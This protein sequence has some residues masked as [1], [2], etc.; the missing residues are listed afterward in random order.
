MNDA[1]GDPRLRASVSS[2][3]AKL[4]ASRESAFA[5]LPAGDSVRDRARAIRA[6]TLAHLDR[7]LAEFAR[8]ARTAGA[9]VHWAED[10]AA[11]TR[12]VVDIA[13][14]HGARLAVKSKSMVTE[15]VAL[16]AALE[17]AGLKV[18]ETDL[19]EFV[20]QVAGEHP[21]HI[22]TPIIHKTRGDV[23]RLFVER[24]G[25]TADEVADV[26]AMTAFARRILRQRFLEADLGISGVNFGVAATGSLCLVTNEGNGRLCTS[27]PRVHIALMGIERVVPTAADLGVMLEVLA[28][29]ATGQVLTVYTNIISG[30]RRP[31]EP[32][33]PDELHIVLVDNGRSR[34]LGSE[35]AEI[36]YCIRCGACLNIC[37][38]YQ[39]MGGHA[40]GSVYPGPVGAVLTPALEASGQW[41]DLPFASTLCGAC[42]DV[43][44]VRIDIPRMLLAL[45]RRVVDAGHGPPWLRAALRVHGWLATRPRAYRLAGRIA[46]WSLARMARD[47][48]VARL[49]GA[50]AAWTRTR[51]LRAPASRSFL[52]RWS[53]G[54]RS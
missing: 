1:L 41:E 47:G 3:A 21:S 35:L 23:A 28:R 53:A 34:V 5:A 22:I 9:Q 38:V 20:V 27:L 45:R 40:Y 30:P 52:R 36:L 33:G 31:G 50:G 54:E 18:V 42:R 8:A 11:A 25:A 24:L 29:S 48:F 12:H 44:P 19:G 4:A 37:P 14:T 49:P 39:A 6:H 32:D 16:N 2:T 51:D 46:A 43:C 10:T 13:T 15:E 7:Y 26:A 17:I